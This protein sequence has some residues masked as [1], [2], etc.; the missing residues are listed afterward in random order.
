MR[1][2]LGRS[3]IWHF[4]FCFFFFCQGTDKIQ[5]VLNHLGKPMPE[6]PRVENYR[7]Q[8][9]L[10]SPWGAVLD[11]FNLPQEFSTQ[12]GHQ[13]VEV[14]LLLARCKLLL[15]K[16]FKMVGRSIKMVNTDI[17]LVIRIYDYTFESGT[18][19]HAS[20][21]VGFPLLHT[22]WCSEIGPLRSLAA[23]ELYASRDVREPISLHRAVYLFP[24]F[25]QFLEAFVWLQSQNITVIAEIFVRVKSS[26]STVHQIS[27]TINVRTAVLVSCTLVHLHGFRMLLN[28]VLST[29]STKYAKLIAYKTF[30]DYSNQALVIIYVT[31]GRFCK[32]N[33]VRFSE[34][35]ASGFWPGRVKVHTN[36]CEPKV[37]SANRKLIFGFIFGSASSVG[38]ATGDF[39]EDFGGNPVARVTKWQSGF[40]EEECLF[41]TL[42][43]F[44]RQCR[45][46]LII[47]EAAAELFYTRESRERRVNGKGTKEKEDY[48]YVDDSWRLLSS[49]LSLSPSPSA[50]C[51]QNT[52]FRLSHDTVRGRDR[53][54]R[55]SLDFGAGEHTGEDEIDAVELDDLENDDITEEETKRA[56][57]DAAS[58][59]PKLPKHMAT[60]ADSNR[61]A[62]TEPKILFGSR[63]L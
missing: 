5:A 23:P 47:N 11:Q 44:A 25:S 41:F 53:W 32:P 39:L 40:G 29:K 24:S 16:L 30:C 10:F 3:S 20:S 8:L 14:D 6:L 28:F 7:V 38:E 36:M 49:P 27:Y 43:C 1:L 60:W 4:I 50:F 55:N 26:Y 34:R 45:A 59:N 9:K 22:A 52:L 19:C 61:P 51:E 37:C 31:L 13:P 48:L 57:V 12:L 35:S 21:L 58:C 42:A 15:V 33:A 56:E 18:L 17:S 46:G 62:W 2:Y 63:A 54:F